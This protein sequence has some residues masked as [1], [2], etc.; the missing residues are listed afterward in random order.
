M[1]KNNKGGGMKAVILVIALMLVG[2][3]AMAQGV[4]LNLQQ[5]GVITWRGEVKNMTGVK[6]Y[7]LVDDKPIS[8]WPKWAKALLVGDC[9][10]A[11]WAY[12]GA[13]LSAGG[14]LIG[15]NLGTI[16]QYVPAIKWDLLNQV[17]VHA[18]PIGVLIERVDSKTRVTGVSGLSI[19]F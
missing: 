14:V 9:A 8:N 16:S 19:K 5:G 17:E 7:E 18:Y 11:I 12:D 3:F 10:T 13:N 4:T 6:A 15:K 1:L 2:S